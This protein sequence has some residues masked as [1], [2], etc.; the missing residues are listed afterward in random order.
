MSSVGSEIGG[1]AA[2]SLDVN[3]QQYPFF[4]SPGGITPQQQSLS[5][6]DYGQNLTEGQAQFEGSGAGGGP[7]LSSMATQVASGANMGKAITSGGMSDVNQGANYGAYG[8]AENIDQQNNQNLLAE[9][10]DNLQTALT[11]V[12]NQQGQAGLTA[13]LSAPLPGATS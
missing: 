7:S 12:G 13:G 2:G 8:I 4:Q 6:Y 5:D 3:Q 10:Q 11:G 1:K 9:N